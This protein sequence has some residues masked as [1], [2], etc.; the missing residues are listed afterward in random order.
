M[1]KHLKI[2]VLLVTISPAVLL[3]AQINKAVQ[4]KLFS[5]SQGERPVYD[6]C[7]L[8]MSSSG[9][10]VSLVTNDANGKF[11]VYE[12]GKKRGP[13]D[14]FKKI[15]QKP[16]DEKNI[17]SSSVY[18]SERPTN[19]EGIVIT[20]DDGNMSIKS[21]AKSYG[22]YQLVF[23]AYTGDDGI[24]TAATVLQDMK[25]NL[26]TQSGTLIK[27]DG[28]PTYTNVSPSGKK[29]L[30]V[31]IKE[32]TPSMDVLKQDISKL[33][34]TEL[35][36]LSKKM[37]EERNNAPP[38]EAFIYFS[39]GKKLGPYP[40]DALSSDNPAFCVTAGENWMMTIDNKLYVNGTLLAN[41]GDEYTPINTIW[42]SP[43]AKRFA[44]IG[45]DKISFSDGSS[46][47][48]PLLI[49]KSL[50]DGK[51]WLTWVSLENEKDIVLY[52]KPL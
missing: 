25:P 35:Q 36:K 21:G 27:L 12:S 49:K 1:N 6:E 22:P 34:V 29:V 4:T 48:F 17:L 5:I 38:P 39:D 16:Q 37:E 41:L 9:N 45:Y 18:V 46:Y 2:L 24:L 33:S 44:I 19:K 26:L 51:I 47:Q 10:T 8:Y 11:Y 23:N 15:I 7:K 3:N 20:N 30:I 14:D 31:A 50:K 40:K 32:Y 52:S 13:I 28:M 42:L 43:D